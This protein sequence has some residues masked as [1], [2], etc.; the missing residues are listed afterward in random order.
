MLLDEA[1]AALDPENEALIQDVLATLADR[2]RT[3][4][5]I[6][7]RLPTSA[8]ADH[9]VVLHPGRVV[10]TGHHQGLLAAG[11][12]YA[13][14]WIERSRTTGWRLAT[15]SP[16]DPS[17][18]LARSEGSIE[19]RR[20]ASPRVRSRS[21]P[22]STSHRHQQAVQAVGDEAHLDDLSR[23]GQSRQPNGQRH[24]NDGR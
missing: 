23:Q 9:L 14:L 2:G 24:L 8:A 20:P 10:E 13:A 5:V 12:R 16:A 7:H 17:A 21:A 15:M 3:V 19:F 11:G 6:A 18:G 4:L 22:V 1:T